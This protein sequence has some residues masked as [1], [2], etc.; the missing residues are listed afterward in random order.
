M[1]RA[2][3]LFLR[4]RPS[5][6]K[7]YY[8]ANARYPSVMARHHLYICYLRAN[9]SVIKLYISDRSMME[10]LLHLP[11]LYLFLALQQKSI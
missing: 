7:M 2:V 5:Y 3:C 6:S 9:E 4:A 1:I 10:A 11:K 8:T